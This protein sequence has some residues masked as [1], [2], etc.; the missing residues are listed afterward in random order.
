MMDMLLSLGP[1]LQTLF[2]VVLVC[3]AGSVLF[4]LIGR[5]EDMTDQEFEDFSPFFNNVKPVMHHYTDKYSGLDDEPLQE[6]DRSGWGKAEP[7]RVM[8]ES[9]D[10]EKI[11][12]E[13]DLDDNGFSDSEE[14]EQSRYPV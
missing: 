3:L 2:I 1:V 5:D 13:E 11:E 12:W 8:S 9:A 6:S 7:V 14:K 10:Q 4:L